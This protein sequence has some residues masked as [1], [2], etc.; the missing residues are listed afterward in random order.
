MDKG[1]YINQLEK[2]LNVGEPKRSE[3]ILELRSHL[4]ESDNK[5]TEIVLGHP[6]TLAIEYN[7]VH[8]GWLNNK[9]NFFIFPFIVGLLYLLVHI[10]L[11]QLSRLL[12]QQYYLVDANLPL[13]VKLISLASGITTLTAIASAI[14][15]GRTLALIHRPAGYFLRL[16]LTLPLLLFTIYRILD[17]FNYIYFSRQYSY[18]VGEAV[19][20]MIT[21]TLILTLLIIFSFSIK[22]S[23]LLLSKGK[24]H[25]KWY[26]EIVMFM[27]MLFV[28]FF[29]AQ[30][31]N[32]FYI[33]FLQSWLPTI[34]IESIIMF[35]FVRRSLS[36]IKLKKTT[37]KPENFEKT[38]T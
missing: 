31:L 8:L 38:I 11:L 30:G 34:I 26:F 15:T 25:R 7:Q 3:L 36:F 13:A 1:E 35:I 6:K 10:L 2:Y 32:T 33:P 19:F 20:S 28:G 37:D 18:E 27:A 14:W 21:S 16:T 9:F 22:K 24:A 4:E 5:Q 17:L 23:P 12:P 29:V